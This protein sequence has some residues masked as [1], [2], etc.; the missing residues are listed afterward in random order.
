MQTFGNKKASCPWKWKFHSIKCPF[1]MVYALFSLSVF[2]QLLLNLILSP[3]ITLIFYSCKNSPSPRSFGR[4]CVDICC[5]QLLLNIC[6]F[7][8]C[9]FHSGEPRSSCLSN[10]EVN[11]AHLWYLWGRSPGTVWNTSYYSG[12]SVLNPACRK[13]QNSV[14]IICL[15]QPSKSVYIQNKLWIIIVLWTIFICECLLSCQAI[16]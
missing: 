14:Y 11:S 3:K 2:H 4:Y 10:Q 7:F 9:R 5:Q 15:L 6:F 12:K 1:K 8:C 13:H 16:L